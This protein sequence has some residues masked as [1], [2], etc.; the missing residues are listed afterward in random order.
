MICRDAVDSNFIHLEQVA[1][2]KN[3]L[4]WEVLLVRITIFL[5]KSE[6]TSIIVFGVHLQSSMN[7][8]LLSIILHNR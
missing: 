5:L 7:V 8:L 4:W 1:F 3:L 2:F 6:L